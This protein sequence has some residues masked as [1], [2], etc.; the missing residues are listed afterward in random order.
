MKQNKPKEDH[1]VA[2][3]TGDPSD[4]NDFEDRVVMQDGIPPIECSGNVQLDQDRPQA[5]L[6]ARVVFIINFSPPGKD[7]PL[8]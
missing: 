5:A 2:D 4:A 6:R 8:R 1:K 3:A 7:H